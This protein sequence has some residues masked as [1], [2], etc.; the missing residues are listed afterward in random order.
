MDI[1]VPVHPDGT[2]DTR[3]LVIINGAATTATTEQG[4][5]G[6]YRSHVRGVAIPRHAGVAGQP[7]ILKGKRIP[8]GVDLCEERGGSP[9]NDF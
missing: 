6:I 8:G 2:A 4:L 5:G 1:E 7:V 3:A 9:N